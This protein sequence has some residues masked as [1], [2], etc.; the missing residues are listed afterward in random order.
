MSNNTR[1]ELTQDDIRERFLTF[2]KERDSKVFASS[3]LVPEDPSLL[4]TNAGMNQ[5]KHYYLGTKTLK[6]GIGATSCQKCLRTNDIDVI[7]LDGRHLSFFEML[8]NF[9]FGGYDKAQACAWALEFCEKELGL[10]KEDLYFTVFK[11]DDEAAL[12]WERLGVLP[13]HISR[14]GEEDNFWAAGPTGPC[15]PCSEIYVDLGPEV[16]CKQPDCAPGCDCDRFLEIWNLVFTQYDRQEDGSLVDLPHQ[17]VDTGMGL[18]RVSAVMKGE[19]SSYKSDVLNTLIKTAE[20][21]FSAKLGTD[22]ATDISLRIIADHARAVSFMLADGILPSNEGRGY[23]L[24]RLLRRAVFHGKLLGATH[25]FFEE[26]AQQTITC[27]HKAYPELRENK[28]HILNVVKAEEARFLETLATGEAYLEEALSAL[29]QGDTLSGD[30][31]FVLHDTYGFPIDLTEEIAKRKG[32]LVDR[33]GFEQAMEEQRT[34][35]REASAT[36]EDAWSNVDIWTEVS[37]KTNPSAFVGYDTLAS[38]ATVLGI[39]KEGSEVKSLQAGESGEVLLDT[40][41]FYAEKGGQVGDTGSLLEDGALF[42]VKNTLPKAGD[43]V[44]HVGNVEEGSISVGDVV[45]ARVDNERRAL[46]A[47]NHTA[48]HLLD[49]ALARVLGDHVK[50]A[51]SLV[52]DTHLRFDFTHYEQLTKEELEH[53]EDLVNEAIIAALPVTTQVMSIEDAR[54]SGAVQL[55]GEKYGEEVRIVTAGPLDD[56]FSKEFCGGTHVTNTSQLGFFKIVSESSVG[57]AA[58]RIEA[59]TSKGALAYVNGLLQGLFQASGILKVNPR[60]IVQAAEGLKE[61]EAQFKTRLKDAISRAGSGVVDEIMGASLDCGAYKTIVAKLE[62]QD[63]KALRALWD[64]IKEKANHPVACF[65]IASTPQ[66]KTALLSAATKEAVE[67]GFNA[68]KLIKE[69]TGALGGRGG[70]RADFA[71]GGLDDPSL[72]DAA[73]KQVKEEL[74]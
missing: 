3:S 44:S 66:G 42:Q 14:L 29:M 21:I 8:G 12:I 25:P 22:E 58:R 47:R 40:T 27:M 17:N 11:D 64:R 71:Q 20:K 57:S 61:R 33:A 19:T 23:V 70:G 18:E 52:T 37:E 28:S 59:V 48:T 7:G 38:S 16:G 60:D 72:R 2:F 4:L 53:V 5:F 26:M 45:E 73:I 30:T 50:Q 36:A 10:S 1:T 6:G 31:A 39:V 56:W 62:E 15:G 55:F 35:A 34:R 69:V 51:G 63:A 32:I 74:S 46:I 67:A 54:K 68:G 41:P 43:L 13:S 9:S 49:A 24:R 65:L